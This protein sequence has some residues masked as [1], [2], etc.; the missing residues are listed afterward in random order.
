MIFIKSE[1]KKE[2][3]SS[4]FGD[5]IVI[6]K[7]IDPR[8]SQ[9]DLF[10]T[11]SLSLETVDLKNWNYPK[12]FHL[13]KNTFQTIFLFNFDKKQHYIIIFCYVESLIINKS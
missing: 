5:L 9:V 13:F 1:I 3:N 10:F 11:G 2:S 7:W 6:S 8:K 4:K 12:I